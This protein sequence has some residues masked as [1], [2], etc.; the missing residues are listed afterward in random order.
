MYYVIVFIEA[1][2]VYNVAFYS[3]IPMAFYTVKL[4]VKH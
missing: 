2:Q 4:E 1:E 3:K